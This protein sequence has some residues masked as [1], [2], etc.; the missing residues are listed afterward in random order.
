M[1]KHRFSSKYLLVFLLVFITLSIVA[2]CSQRGLISKKYSN[3]IYQVP[4]LIS[5]T[6]F[7]KNPVFIVYG[8]IRPGFRA[9]EKFLK[10]KNWYTWKMLIFP[11][12]EIYLLGNGISGFIDFLRNE[13]N[14]GY[15][16]RIMVRDALYNEAKN[17]NVDFILSVGDFVNDGRYPSQWMKFIKEYKIE[18]PFLT[19][20]PYFPTIGGHDMANDT[21]FGLKNYKSVFQ[22]PRFYVIECPNVDI[23][24]VDSHIIL[25][26]KQLIDD[27]T[28]D[29]LFEK[30]FVSN[31]KSEQSAWLERKLAASDKTFKIIS[32]H[33]PPISFGRHNSD[34]TQKS[35]GRNLENKR[36][37]LLKM[38]QKYDV[39]IV[40]CGH[41]HLYER[42][43]LKYQKD[44]VNREIQIII[45]G[46]G[47]VPLRS[48]SDAKK[49][50]E[51]TNHYEN[52]GLNVVQAKQAEMFHYCVVDIDVHRVKIDII[53]VKDE[54]EEAV[55][56][57]ETIF[58]NKN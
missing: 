9:N 3:E 25:D 56:L 20:I 22:Y 17:S 55:R 32:I 34:W 40:F 47:G 30:W 42:N 10:R 38:F 18:H 24:V 26:D 44:G 33:N 8:D 29:K 58:V 27:D 1:N 28:Q 23:F 2:A 50:R 5:D 21:T 19:E 35:Y 57:E 4:K 45:S 51:Y 41:E 31:E 36:K 43:V 53:E 7:K 6:S 54:A 39:Q 37:K 52:I 14:Y 15:K 11:F 13:S 46:G 49:I 48:K 12:Y 16:E